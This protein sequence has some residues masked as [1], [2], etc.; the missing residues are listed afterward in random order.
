MSDMHDASEMGGTGAGGQSAGGAGEQLQ[1]TGPLEMLL[2]TRPWVKF[3]A[4]LG[5]IMAG[6]MFA[7]A[8]L[9]II[10]GLL[11]LVGGMSAG[12]PPG[13]GAAGAALGLG[14]GLFYVALA[15][16]YLFPPLFLWRYGNRISDYEMTRNV[17]D[18][19]EAL[20]QQ[21]AFWRFVGIL[22]LVF[23]ILGIAGMALVVLIGVLGGLMA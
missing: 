6:L 11:M 20:R 23:L 22:A 21:K 13:M 16:L 2:M 1:D 8:A 3:L 17:A 5:F 4:V 19:T 14:V 9:Y 18:L 15:V 10:M 7:A 12:A